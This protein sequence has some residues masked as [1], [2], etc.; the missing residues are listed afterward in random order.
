MAV[1]PAIPRRPHWPLLLALT[2]CALA[3]SAPA[4]GQDSSA[5]AATDQDCPPAPEVARAPPPTSPCI[6][7]DARKSVDSLAGP[8]TFRWQMGDGQVREGVEFEYCYAALGRYVIQLD[9]LDGTTG[10]VRQHETERVVDF[11]VAPAPRPELFLHFTAPAKAKVGEPVEFQLVEADLPS[12]LSSTVRYNWNF[13]DGL[14]A[15]GRHVTH[16]FRRAGTFAVRAALDGSLD[17]SCLPRTC[18]TRT[19]VIEP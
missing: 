8:L 2:F 16:T 7:L 6:L 18:V 19:I 10:E 4:R 11:T 14:L 13:R 17:A 5:A 9:V 3:G 1:F 12:C 15:Q